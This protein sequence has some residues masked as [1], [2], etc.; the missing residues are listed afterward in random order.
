MDFQTYEDEKWLILFLLA[1]LI[2]LNYSYSL[3]YPSIKSSL[4]LQSG[5][6]KSTEAKLEENSKLCSSFIISSEAVS[7]KELCIS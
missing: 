6:K 7:V 1:C 3:L 2:F 4:Q 5:N